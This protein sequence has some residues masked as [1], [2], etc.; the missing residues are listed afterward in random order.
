MQAR[1]PVRVAFLVV[2][3][4]HAT[5]HLLGFVKGFGLAPVEA[6]KLPIGR[7]A[8]ALWLVATLA[9]VATVVLAALRWE[10]WWWVA[11]GSL[12]LSQALVVAAWS[13]A[14]AGTIANV[15]LALGALAALATSRFEAEGRDRLDALLASAPS[16][17]GAVVT[18][19]EV[20]AT[21]PAVRR[22]L[23]RAGVV[24]K[25]R[26]RV[27]RLR[28]RGQMQNEPGAGFRDVR[29]DQLFVPDEAAFLWRVRLSMFGLPVVGR[30]TFVGGHGRMRIVVAG[31]VPVADAADP[32]IDE[33]A[34]LR[35]LGETVWFP[36]AALDPRITWSPGEDPQRAARATIRVGELEAEAELDFD[37]E[38][39]FLALRADR[40]RGG[41][42][43][44]ERAPWRVNARAWRRFEGV[45]VPSEGDVVWVLPE[46]DFVFYRWTIETLETDVRERLPDLR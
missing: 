38:G 36:S 34:M 37:D 30:D 42:P 7:V 39:R 9:L 20:D 25:P 19:A 28:Q 1:P 6:L 22:W 3:A 44:A 32:K 16:S 27:V 4:L 2:V 18:D 31:L 41:G 43:D 21:P 5:I 46:G 24:G 45:E 26:P 17:E 23:R 10:G 11:L 40:Y 35:Y 13:D 8:G 15:I 33:G 29:A 14:K 12:L